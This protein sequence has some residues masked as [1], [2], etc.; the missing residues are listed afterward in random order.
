MRVVVT[1]IEWDGTMRRQM[2]DTAGR[3]DAEHIEKLTG[4][5]L[6]F[7]PPYRPAPGGIVYHVRADDQV[8]LVADCDLTW[9]L[10]DL[11]MAVLAKG[12]P[13]TGR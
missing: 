13:C 6:A 3:S 2:I 9:P 5:A 8:I 10:R 1:R 4:R 7:P 11:V 12:N